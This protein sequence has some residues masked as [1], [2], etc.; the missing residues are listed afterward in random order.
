MYHVV[1]VGVCL[2]L[3]A[4]VVPPD[5]YASAVSTLFERVNV[6]LNNTSGPSQLLRLRN[7]VLCLTRDVGFQ[8]KVFQYHGFFRETRSG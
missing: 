6:S 8:E 2:A 3:L 5:A 7:A 4:S 1:E